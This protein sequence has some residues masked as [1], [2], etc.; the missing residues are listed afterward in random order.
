MNFWYNV[1]KQTHTQSIFY[2]SFLLVRT[3][4]WLLI[5][6]KVTKINYYIQIYLYY[7]NSV[8]FSGVAQETGNQ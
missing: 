8:F 1:L 7:I 3:Q 5:Y 4:A 6:L 2:S